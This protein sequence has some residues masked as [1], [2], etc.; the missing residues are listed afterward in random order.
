M[1][2]DNYYGVKISDPYRNL[3]NLEDSV[4][5]NWL[6]QQQ[7]YTTNTLEAI[8]KRS[9]FIKKLQQFDTQ[10]SFEISNMKV[11]NNNIYFYLK[12]L[13]DEDLGKLYYRKNLDGEEH[14][15][16]STENYKKNDSV[17]YKID[18]IEPDWKGEKVAVSLSK[19]G[20]EFS[21][22]IFIDVKKNIILSHTLANCAP[23]TLGSI[24]WLSDNSGVI[25]PRIVSKDIYS[26]GG[27]LENTESVLFKFN[28]YPKTHEIIL[29]AATQKEL[30]I[31]PED[32]PYA[33]FNH[34]TVSS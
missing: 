13:A 34:S 23:T 19:K 22:I 25:Y 21:E 15:L 24:T 14:L 9:E 26:K 20:S 4:V 18:Y 33:F 10:K 8:P 12:R 16:Y 31:N 1:T 32:F 17:I 29:S 2:I 5:I 27:I 28:E 30:K 6:K 11:T 3:E 7:K